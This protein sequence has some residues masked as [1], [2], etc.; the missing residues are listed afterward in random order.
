MVG[1]T[2][3]DLLVLDECESIFTTVI[4]RT[5]KEKLREHAQL[6]ENM[7]KQAQKVILLDADLSMK[8]VAVMKDIIVEPQEMIVS[9][10]TKQMVKRNVYM[11][12]STDCWKACLKREIEARKKICVVLASKTQG[13][14]IETEILKVLGQNTDFIMENVPTLP[15]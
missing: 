1:C 12:Q 4:S 9:I 11:H 10:N 7:C 5:N 2:C 13:K 6:F 15:I 8:S 14:Q 3:Y